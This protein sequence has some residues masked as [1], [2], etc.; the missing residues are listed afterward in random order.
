M[1]N[2]LSDILLTVKSQSEYHSKQAKK[3]R[4]VNIEKYYK[5][6]SI[7]Q[8]LHEAHNILYDIDRR[9]RAEKPKNS[10]ESI[11]SQEIDLNTL[12]RNIMNFC[13]QFPEFENLDP[14]SDD[15]KYRQKLSMLI[16]Y[17]LKDG[18]ELSVSEI[19]DTVI[20]IL[21]L[22]NHS[23]KEN[24]HIP[25]Q[26]FHLEKSLRQLSKPKKGYYIIHNTQ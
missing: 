17:A 16:L 26:L 20:S 4:E 23:L 8:D 21:T 10:I 22:Y 6:R 19:R 14:F 13:G 1:N 2:N 12:K 9:N 24:A 15:T 25:T 18:I 3:T 11:N 7:A 5:H